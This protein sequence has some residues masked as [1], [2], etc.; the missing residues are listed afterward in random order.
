MNNVFLVL[1]QPALVIKAAFDQEF[2]LNFPLGE[3][4][5]IQ[6]V[7]EAFKIY[8]YYLLIFWFSLMP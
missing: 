3:D 2:K 8:K 1:K 5:V 6:I 7:Q 4:T